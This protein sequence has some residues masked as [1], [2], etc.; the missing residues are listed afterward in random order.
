MIAAASGVD[1][2]ITNGSKVNLLKNNVSDCQAGTVIKAEIEC[3]QA[4]KRVSR[5]SQDKIYY[6]HAA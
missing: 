4:K 6:S 2:I 5:F 1:T 3:L